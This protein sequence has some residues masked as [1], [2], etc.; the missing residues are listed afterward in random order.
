MNQK[1]LKQRKKLICELLEDPLYVPMKEKEL[2]IFLQVKPEER[3]DLKTVLLELLA[4]NKIQISKRG[5]YTK[6]SRVMIT[7]S[8]IGNSRGF[9][10]VELDEKEKNPSAG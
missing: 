5:K 8:F 1:E 10:F 9:G 7:G 2:A 6:G 3:D 4:E